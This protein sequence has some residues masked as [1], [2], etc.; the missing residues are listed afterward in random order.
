M[1]Y[2]SNIEFKIDLWDSIFMIKESWNEVYRNIITDCFEHVGFKHDKTSDSCM[3][4]IVDEKNDSINIFKGL[5][6]NISIL[7]EVSKTTF[8]LIQILIYVRI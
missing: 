7:Q 4:Y 8:C 6:K 5:K 2:D 1:C 3:G